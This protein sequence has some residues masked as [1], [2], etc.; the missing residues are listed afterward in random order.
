MYTDGGSIPRLLWSVPGFSPWGYGPAYIVHD[1]LFAAKHCADPAY[2]WVTFDDSA[3]A[4]GE[5]IKTLMEQDIA[6]KSPELLYLIVEAV[7]TPI[8]HDLWEHG[9]C[10]VPPAGAVQDD[11]GAAPV[12][13]TIDLSRPPRQ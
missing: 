9:A 8:A 12:I 6:R 3:R 10:M 11:I 13:M 5:S 2:A 7:K 4:L 1:W